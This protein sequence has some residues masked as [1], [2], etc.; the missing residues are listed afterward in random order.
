LI[1]QQVID[2]ISEEYDLEKN[3][4]T[5]DSNLITDLSLDSL[6]MISLGY[7]LEKKFDLP[8][9]DEKTNFETVNDVVRYIKQVKY[10]FAA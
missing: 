10:H 6:D 1:E 3:G 5:R 9:I 4:I 8:P 2:F 7:D